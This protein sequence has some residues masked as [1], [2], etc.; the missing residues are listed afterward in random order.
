MPANSVIR[1]S[2]LTDLDKRV[3]KSAA[4]WSAIIKKATE[5]GFTVREIRGMEK[6]AS[7]WE[8][9]FKEA[10]T[11]QMAFEGQ[12]RDSAITAE[13]RARAEAGAKQVKED[14]KALK[15]KQALELA[16]EGK[17]AER[18]IA[19]LDA[20]KKKFGED[21]DRSGFS[22][23]KAED[24]GQ[25]IGDAFGEA[26]SGD[27][28]DIGKLI[29]R[30]GGAAAKGGGKLEA[31]AGAKDGGVGKSL[32]GLG[33]VIGSLGKVLM[34]AAGVFAVFAAI[35][36]AIL[37]ADAKT[38]ELNREIFSAGIAGADLADTYGNVTDAINST[39]TAFTKA[40]AF[41][42]KWGTLAKDNLEILGQFAEAG[43]TFKEITAGARNAKEEMK[44]LQDAT[45]MTLIY[46]KLLGKSAGEI[47]VDSATLM[48]DFGFTL[49]GVKEQFG[50]IISVAK[51]SGFA[52]KR[53]Y[54]MILQATS[55]MSMYNIRLSET[56]ELLTMLG[57]TLG[58]NL[59]G[60]YLSGL[61]KGFK[62][63]S[64]E[65][66]IRKTLTTGV[67]RSLDILREGAVDAAEDFQHALKQFATG[68]K[69]KGQDFWAAM[70][71]G[72]GK[73]TKVEDV[74][75]MGA[76][77]LARALQKMP[78]EMQNSM[79]AAASASNPDLARQLSA[80]MGK[81]QAFGEGLSAAQAARSYA[82]PAEALA[83]QLN[84]LQRVV[85]KRVDQID[86]TNEKEMM[87]VDKQLGLSAEEV[88]KL[89]AIGGHYAGINDMMLEEQEKIK[90]L[91]PESAMAE[92][93][94]WNLKYA[95]EFGY[96]VDQ[97]GQRF[98]ATFVPGM[99]TAMASGG[100]MEDSVEGLI[101]GAGEAVQEELGE[102]LSQDLM[103]AMEIADNTRD[104]AHIMEAGTNALLET[105]SGTV[106]KIIGWLTGSG[107]TKESR[108]T[109][110][111]D[112]KAI[113]A[114]QYK[115]KLGLYSAQ[116]QLRKDLR[117]NK[118]K[119]EEK[120]QKEAEAEAVSDNIRKL[121]EQ[122][123]ITRDVMARIGTSEGETPEE[124]KAAARIGSRLARADE[125]LPEE[126]KEELKDLAATLAEEAVLNRFN[127]KEEDINHEK[128]KPGYKVGREEERI[129]EMWASY[130]EEVLKETEA[131][132]DRLLKEEITGYDAAL[133]TQTST[134]KILDDKR[135]EA[136]IKA[137]DENT[138]KLLKSG[139]D[140]KFRELTAL[141]NAT[142]AGT[143]D[144]QTGPRMAESFLKGV[145]MG[146]LTPEQTDFF[147]RLDV[148][149]VKGLN[150]FM[151]RGNR[152]IPFSSQDDVIGAK[153]GGPLAGAVGGGG[154][155]VNVTVHNYNDGPGMMR[156]FNRAVEAGLV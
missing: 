142:P 72:M 94:E 104:M 133:A 3:Q 59:A 97:A 27:I 23:E 154:K 47:A 85:G 18:R 110:T 73:G 65:D 77:E 126:R 99:D 45:E 71:K 135:N 113:L 10:I 127:Q 70:A 101:L 1:S 83:L 50:A 17:V 4:G 63:E 112:Y 118:Y 56:A 103:T 68:N 22:A 93:L 120:K 30:L 100:P 21:L 35:G 48:S 69:E 6:A 150:D 146:K 11:R 64:T 144:T 75:G 80:V 34:V 51:D 155:V 132:N 86:T 131:Q 121:E 153:V 55:G 116:V 107:D 92:S 138:K 19:A 15:A 60:D 105:I 28:S 102:T 84:E 152:V 125:G 58:Q 139:Q 130:G 53:F 8:K 114:L 74:Q 78:K 117:G 90:K 40:I 67:K 81:S 124:V 137:E 33:K 14:I 36:K 91:D 42:M 76:E 87:L 119:G 89:Q 95:K 49:K 66:R 46:S 148:Q 41:N 25:S 57:K 26:I 37:D 108:M 156:T 145:P 20:Y 123:S 115:E 31:G 9:S 140:T 122:I 129:K 61:V 13:A 62:D 106:G 136:L 54:G 2:P 109:A 44:R 82:G 52:T 151:V 43:Y 149:G 16:G 141:M 128:F 39:R 134:Q 24:F 32:G 96:M 79:L 29:K 143:F 12:L 98:K 38:K 111:D 5:K 7:K 88:R 147:K